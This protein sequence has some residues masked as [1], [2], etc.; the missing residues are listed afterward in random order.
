MSTG[1]AQLQRFHH[2]SPHSQH[3]PPSNY[4]FEFGLDSPSVATP[5]RDSEDP[6]PETELGKR[7]RRPYQYAYP[8]Q[9]PSS[10]PDRIPFSHS[11]TSRIDVSEH[12]LRRKTPSGTLAAGY[13]GTPVEW[14]KRSHAIKHILMPTS[15]VEGFPL[16]H[17][18]TGPVLDGYAV[19]SKSAI[20][21]NID[22]HRAWSWNDKTAPQSEGVGFMSSIGRESG[23]GQ[24]ARKV[25]QPPSLDSM[26]NQSPLPQQPYYS[27][28]FHPVPTVL[29]PVWPLN[30][31]STASSEQGPYGPYWPNGSFIPYRPAAFRDVRFSPAMEG[32]HG[33][34][35]FDDPAIIRKP[36]GW[37]P[38]LQS[39]AQKTKSHTTANDEDN[40]WPTH[41]SDGLFTDDFGSPRNLYTMRDQVYSLDRIQPG[42]EHI[43]LAPLANQPKHYLGMRK[44]W[45]RDDG[46][47]SPVHSPASSGSFGLERGIPETNLQCKEKVLAWAHRIYITLLASLHQSRKH[48]HNKQ[49]CG[50]RHSS[51]ACIY[52]RPPGQLFPASRPTGSTSQKMYPGNRGPHQGGIDSTLLHQKFAACAVQV[53][54]G[55]AE[56]SEKS[57]WP[58]SPNSFLDGGN[59]SNENWHL[60]KQR[61][62]PSHSVQSPRHLAEYAGRHHA[63]ISPTSVSNP[64]VHS[65]SSNAKTALEI[66]TRL[67]QESDW[68]WTDGLLL[69]GCL[70][71]GLADYDKAL[72]WYS[73]VLDCDPK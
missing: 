42:T 38:G 31:G 5:H 22:E 43:Q 12:M 33:N 57:P 25:P 19:Y 66:L 13:D 32:R 35:V 28:G 62:T 27:M 47:W 59:N 2:F 64:H 37:S 9:S 52:P 3:Y 61:I 71:Y 50:D 24:W 60:G 40:H 68:Q 55:Q 10:I 14:T 11:P 21:A 67:C 39:T 23:S 15:G 7:L 44:D 53:P 18:P 63:L 6:P 51:N 17:F 58:C 1:I 36:D 56:D 41:R 45:N 30:F 54:D 26:L 48:A 65:P 70:A 72:Q 34:E 29:Q 16:D 49:Q 8:L 69:G 4:P 46:I 73:K 20:P